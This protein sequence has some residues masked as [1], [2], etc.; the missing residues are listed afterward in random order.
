LQKKIA[1]YKIPK[2]FF[3]WPENQAG[4]KPDRLNLKILAEGLILNI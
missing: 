2:F 4:L 1:S 3:P